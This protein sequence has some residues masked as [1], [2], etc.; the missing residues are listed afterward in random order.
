MTGSDPA[1][2][3]AART[4]DLWGR[5]RVEHAGRIGR[6]LVRHRPVRF[7][8]RGVAYHPRVCQHCLRE[9][10][11]PLGH[12]TLCRGLA[13][14]R[15]FARFALEFHLRNRGFA[16]RQSPLPQLGEAAPHV[17]AP[18]AGSALHR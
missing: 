12:W 8:P 14:E 10:F 11:T 18:R 15:V 4:R 1:R 2:A 6:V 7:R 17:R 9:T 13:V 3:R 5:P 16:P